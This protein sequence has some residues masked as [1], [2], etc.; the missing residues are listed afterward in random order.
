MCQ[1]GTPFRNVLTQIFKGLRKIEGNQRSVW[2]GTIKVEAWQRF[3]IG[4][5]KNFWYRR[6]HIPFLAQ[7]S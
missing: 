5:S 4:K 3:L 7:L 2:E 1:L 6:H